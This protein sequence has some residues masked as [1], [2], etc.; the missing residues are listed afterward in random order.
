MD[1]TIIHP[2]AASTVG[3]HYIFNPFRLEALTEDMIARHTSGMAYF[4]A[5][6]YQEIIPVTLETGQG[7]FTKAKGA[8]VFPMVTVVARDQQLLIHCSCTQDSGKLCESQA[9]V[10]TAILK[11]EALSVFFSS[12]LRTGKIKTFAADYGLASVPDPDD[13]FSITFRDN[14]LVITPRMSSLLPVTVESLKLMNEVIHPAATGPADHPAEAG[15]KICVVLR[16]HKYYRYLVTELYSA[17]ATKDNRIK[18]PLH[19]LQPLDFI[20]QAG[21]PDHVKSKRPLRTT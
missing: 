14:T 1:N 9:M 8:I 4:E 17:A 13:F 10:L 12:T 6:T 3:H 20:W 7:T 16:R 18:N 21:D 19:I 5:K 15:I 11:R 2:A